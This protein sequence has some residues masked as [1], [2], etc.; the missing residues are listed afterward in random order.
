MTTACFVYIKKTSQT[1]DQLFL[2]QIW[3]NKCT[4]SKNTEKNEKNIMYIEFYFLSTNPLVQLYM[5]PPVD[6]ARVR[7]MY[8]STT[9]FP[10]NTNSQKTCKRQSNDKRLTFMSFSALP[11]SRQCTDIFYGPTRQISYQK[12]LILLLNLNKLHFINQYWQIILENFIM[13]RTFHIFFSILMQLQSWFVKRE[14]NITKNSS[15]FK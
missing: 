12:I 11:L 10:N 15:Q 13:I 8:K 3:A 1:S 5:P 7:A 6:P 4:Y 14:S 2:P 9:L